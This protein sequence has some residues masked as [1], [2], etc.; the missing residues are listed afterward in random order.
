MP[1]QKKGQ[2]DKTE[3]DDSDYRAERAKQ[4]KK[5]GKTPFKKTAK[6][7][8][9]PKTVGEIVQATRNAQRAQLAKQYPVDRA[10]PI[11]PAHDYNEKDFNKFQQSRTTP[12]AI[13]AANNPSAPPHFSFQKGVRGGCGHWNPRVIYD[14]I[15]AARCENCP[16]RNLL[17]PGVHCKGPGCGWMYQT[18]KGMIDAF[19]REESNK[20]A[21]PKTTIL[22]PHQGVMGGYA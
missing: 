15:N 18:H 20:G 9:A 12:Y 6:D 1:R 11:H 8:D 3:S 5:T 16:R 14:S 4:T 7:P 13:C 10:A 19:E 22:C 17:K 2:V 21:E